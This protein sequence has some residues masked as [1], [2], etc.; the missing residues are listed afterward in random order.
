MHVHLSRHE[1]IWA[2]IV[3]YTIIVTRTALALLGT[4]YIWQALV[5]HLLLYMCQPCTVTWSHTMYQ[6]AVD[7]YH[8]ILEQRFTA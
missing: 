1:C 6:L 4:F 3:Y 8:V 5:G 2:T 7:L